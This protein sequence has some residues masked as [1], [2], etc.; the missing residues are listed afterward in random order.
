[1]IV[2]LDLKYT[3][4]GI[5][6]IEDISSPIPEIYYLNKIKTSIYRE[7]SHEYSTLKRIKEI[8]DEVV[9]FKDAT[10][11]IESYAYSRGSKGRVFDLAELGGTIKWE[12]SKFSEVY[13]IEIGK[14]KKYL[15]GNG[16]ADKIMIVKAVQDE[17]VP[18]GKYRDVILSKKF[19]D[20]RADAINMA[21]IGQNVL[22][23][24]KRSAEREKLAR[25]IRKYNHII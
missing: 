9:K 5:C 2:G 13:T 6:V 19:D 25:E 3:G 15:T 17:F 24:V 18:E 10:F 14:A 20:D 12:I 21:L 4:T 23:Y 1:M 22:G 7:L 11:F 8:C 16:R